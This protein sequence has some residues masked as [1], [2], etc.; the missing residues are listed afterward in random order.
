MMKSRHVWAVVVVWVL[1]GVAPA[2]PAY[3]Y[4]LQRFLAL[5]NT[6]AAHMKAGRRDEAEATAREMVVV[7]E[8][9]DEPNPRAL[10]QW[11][12]L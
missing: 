11:Y 2:R 10:A 6:Y 8:Q 7:A 1:G 3:S 5:K 9:L 12:L 4:E